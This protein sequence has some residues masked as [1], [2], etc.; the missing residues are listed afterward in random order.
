MGVGSH[1]HALS[2]VCPLYRWMGW[3]QGQ[4]GWLW[5]RENLLPM[6]RFITTSTSKYGCSDKTKIA[7]NKGTLVLCFKYFILTILRIKQQ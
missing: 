2:T 3:A 7:I 1:S 6:P 5:T 4:S